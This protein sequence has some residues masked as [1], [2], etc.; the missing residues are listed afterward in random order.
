MSVDL[1]PTKKGVVGDLKYFIGTATFD[2]AYTGEEG[3]AID[4]SRFGFGE[5]IYTVS[6]E[7][8]DGCVFEFDHAM[9]R[10]RVK[11]SFAFAEASA[12]G[13]VDDDDNAASVGVQVYVVVD[14][15]DFI[16]GFA[17]G[18]FEFVSPTDTDGSVTTSNGGPTLRIIDSD[19]AA[20]NGVALRVLA[21][22]AGFEA[23]LA[24]TQDPV[25]VPVSNGTYVRVD[26]T[27]T[28]STP[29]VYCDEDA[30]NSYER[31]K[32]VVVDNGNETF[33]FY[34]TREAVAQYGD[35]LS[36]VVARVFALGK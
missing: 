29:N 15:Q 9:N 19:D 10:V 1:T 32:A 7:P 20:T 36:T 8:V 25:L 16:P 34:H 4:I 26:D 33:S 12:T 6:F 22:G 17:L 11:R 28:G 35:D 31:L 14:E 3:E 21:A 18:H 13:V 24:G 27:T 23:T 2:S 30:S 5:D